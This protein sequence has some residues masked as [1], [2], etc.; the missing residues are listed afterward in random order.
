MEVQLTGNPKIPV[1]S[2]T[3]ALQWSDPRQTRYPGLLL[4]GS[5]GPVP[6][7]SSH[8]RPGGTTVS[9]RHDGQFEKMTRTK[10]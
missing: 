3:P 8:C 4:T 7:N 6:G 1:L 5:I 2:L 10:S 9:G